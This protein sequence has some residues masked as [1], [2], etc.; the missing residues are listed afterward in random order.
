MSILKDKYLDNEFKIIIEKHKIASY[1]IAETYD[2]LAFIGNYADDIVGEMIDT[3]KVYSYDE[4]DAFFDLSD[5]FY[6]LDRGGYFFD[7]GCNILTTAVY[8]LKKRRELQAVGFE[9]VNRTWRIAKANAALNNMDERIRVINL[10]L[11]DQKG[12]AQMRCSQYSCGG[13]YIFGENDGNSNGL[14]EIEEVHT[15]TL[16]EWIEE[17]NFD[18]SSIK[19]LWIDTEGYEG[20]VL[21]GMMKLLG[22]RKIPMYIEF[23]TEFLRR[24]GCLDILL[25]CLEKTYSKYI[26]VKRG[27]K[28]DISEIHKIKELRN[29]KELRENIFLI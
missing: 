22:Q 23:Y 5:R 18:V 24:S 12:I 26:V 15:I 25:E 7:C 11:S 3:G 19:Y 6:S 14:I 16:D 13:N 28:Y 29:M 17:N 2:G 1:G 4:I 9:P 20:Y 21:K 10:A 8:A 27:G